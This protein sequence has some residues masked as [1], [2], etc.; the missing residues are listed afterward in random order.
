MFGHKAHRNGERSVDA[1]FHLQCWAGHLR[2]KGFGALALK[3]HK[4]MC[5]SKEE[6]FVLRSRSVT[7]IYIYIFFF[8]SSTVLRPNIA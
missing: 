2:S 1:Q 5:I 6:A 8:K 4:K 7:D 3:K